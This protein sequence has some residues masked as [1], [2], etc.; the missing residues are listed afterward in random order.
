MTITRWAVPT[1]RPDHH[2]AACLQRGRD[3][4]A[5]VARVARQGT[6]GYLF[7]RVHSS[8]AAGASSTGDAVERHGDTAAQG[9]GQAARVSRGGAATVGTGSAVCGVVSRGGARALLTG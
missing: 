7:R 9:A 6:L 3:R 1:G 4:G 2:C 5:A 8:A